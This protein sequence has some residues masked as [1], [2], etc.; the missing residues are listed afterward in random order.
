MCEVSR[1]WGSLQGSD[2]LQHA[3][4]FTTLMQLRHIAAASNTLLADEHPWDLR[5]DQYKGFRAATGKFV[6][7]H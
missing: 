2:R 1:T 5:S 6:F 3:L 4:Q 7:S